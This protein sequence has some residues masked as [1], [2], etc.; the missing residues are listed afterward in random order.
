MFDNGCL[1][2]WREVGEGPVVALQ[3]QL[4]RQSTD[5]ITWNIRNIDLSYFCVLPL[6]R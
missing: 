6:E 3:R 2:E 5:G 1:K 4:E